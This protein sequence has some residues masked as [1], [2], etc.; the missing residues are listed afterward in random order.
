MG[1]PQNIDN[2]QTQSRHEDTREQLSGWKWWHCPKIKTPGREGQ[3]L[4]VI[5]HPGYKEIL[6]KNKKINK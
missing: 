3:K 1:S 2:I 5:G 4:Q 6:S